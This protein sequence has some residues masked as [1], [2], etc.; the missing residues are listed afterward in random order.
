[1]PA[2]SGTIR[3]ISRVVAPAGL[4]AFSPLRLTSKLK[5]E[6][7]RSNTGASAKGKRS[8]AIIDPDKAMLVSSIAS[9]SGKL[10]VILCSSADYG[11]FPALGSRGASRRT[12][13]MR[14]WKSRRSSKVIGLL[15][16]LMAPA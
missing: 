3:T 6:F 15:L 14:S 11:A 4:P 10:S 12:E 2:A 1:V 5:S 9:S 13:N 8:K 16:M 7:D